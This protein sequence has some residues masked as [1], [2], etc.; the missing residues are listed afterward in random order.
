MPAEEDIVAP[1]ETAAPAPE[2]TE[3]PAA[4]EPEAA[5]EAKPE[6]RSEAPKWAF[7]RIGEETTKRQAAEERAR[8]AERRAAEFE[9]IVQRLQ[10][11]PSDPAKPA[12]SPARQE[13]SVDQ[14][15]VQQE[16][17]RQLLQ[18]DLR[19]VSEA[20]AKE[21]GAKWNDAVA[22]LDACGANSV[23]FVQG[24][25]ELDPANAHKIMFQIA[26]DPES[27]VRLTRMN[28]TRRGAEI[29]RMI[30]AS[31]AAVKPE[32][33]SAKT[34]PGPKPAISRAPAPKPAMAPLAPV[35]QIDPRN[36]EDND[37]MTDAEFEAW[38]KKTYYK[39]AG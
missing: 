36:P 13:N 14:S 6:P 12:T 34:E 25:I 1:I 29:T 30:M 24:V 35:H 20:G 19:N 38:Y 11:Q 16:A 18:R 23:D 26:Q 28:A 32:P 33:K 17:A 10:Q 27:A 15:A 2:V 21:F 4:V 22:A 5:P 9:Q 39:K 3:T 7:E 8:A 37:K 31:D